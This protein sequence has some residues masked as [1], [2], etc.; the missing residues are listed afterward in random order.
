MSDMRFCRA[1]V[2]AVKAKT[3]WLGISFQSAK[4]KFCRPRSVRP[5]LEHRTKR[6]TG[7]RA[8]CGSWLAG[9][10]LSF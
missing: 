4:E 6:H 9:S 3:D 8:D 5:L 10:V 2:R 1:Q 7:R